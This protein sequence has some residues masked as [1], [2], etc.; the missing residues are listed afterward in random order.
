MNS[1]N[2]NTALVAQQPLQVVNT[3][4]QASNLMSYRLPSGDD[5][6]IMVELSKAFSESGMY[7]PESGQPFSPATCLAILMTGLDLGLT[8]TQSMM[9]IYS[10]MGKPTISSQLMAA[11]CLQRKDICLYFTL[12][13]TSREVATFE[14]LRAGSPAPVVISYT[15]D[16]AKF[17]GLLGKNNWKLDGPGMLVNR[18]QSRIARAVYPDLTRGMYTREEIEDRAYAENEIT[19][20]EGKTSSVRNVQERLAAKRN[21]AVL[22]AT[23]KDTDNEPTLAELSSVVKALRTATKL[24]SKEAYSTYLQEQHGIDGGSLAGESRETI[25]AVIQDLQERAEA[26]AAAQ[27]PSPEE[28][29][30]PDGEQL[31]KPRTCEFEG[32]GVTL[33]SFQADRSIAKFNCFVCADHEGK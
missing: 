17:A 27:N 8:P 20:T 23:K 18:C 31:T 6:R 29:A 10:V 24:G 28:Q 1:M 9:S 19:K 26:I 16:D 2:G 22:P 13:E 3:E 21:A 14:T 12:I 32:C 30:N 7:K 25:Q 15:L 4:P 11:L 5:L 33:S